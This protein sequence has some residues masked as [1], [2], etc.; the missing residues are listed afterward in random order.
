M[1]AVNST[2]TKSA[3]VI[4]TIIPV[5]RKVVCSDFILLVDSETT[6]NGPRCGVLAARVYGNTERAVCTSRSTYANHLP[7]SVSGLSPYSRSGTSPTGIW[8]RH[9][10]SFQT[11]ADE[12]SLKE[13]FRPPGGKSINER[14]NPLRGPIL[15][16]LDMVAAVPGEAE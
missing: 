3:S 6:R 1:C 15:P 8:I 10:R 2:A 11:N 16:V 12:E 14:G 4:A 13:R 7:G 9:V 5:L